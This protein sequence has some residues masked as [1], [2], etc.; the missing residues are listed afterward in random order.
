M[1]QQLSNLAQ[2]SALAQHLGGQSMA[3]LVCPFGRGVDAGTF[4]RM[5]NQGANATRPAKGADRGFS[6]QEYAAAGC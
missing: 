5:P 3:K 2:R 4:E 6:A 1:P